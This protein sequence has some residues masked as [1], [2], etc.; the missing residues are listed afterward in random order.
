LD[1]L[2]NTAREMIL[3]LFD[4]GV[5]DEDEATLALLSISLGV[6]HMQTQHAERSDGAPAG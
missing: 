5:L 2:A 1:D 4:D 6:R 3:R